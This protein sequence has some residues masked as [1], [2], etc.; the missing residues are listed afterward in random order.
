MQDEGPAPAGKEWPMVRAAF[1]IQETTNR[2]NQLLLVSLRWVAVAGQIAAIGA[3]RFGLGIPLP[4]PQMGAVIAC[5]IALNL[6][7]RYRHAS[8]R[9]VTDTELFLE[10]LLDVAALTV[11][12]YL[13]GGATNPFVSLFL[14]Q[15]ILG[16]V[17]LRPWATWLIVAVTSA[18]FVGLMAWY[19]D[20]GFIMPAHD[21][22]RPRLLELHIYG[23]FICFLLAAVLLVLFVTRINR[24]L[25]GQDLRLAG[26]RQQSAEEEHIVRMGLLASGAAHELGT[27][28]ATLS[29]ILNDWQRMPALTA[30]PDIATEIGEMQAQLARCKDIVSGILRSS[31]E[32][33]GEGAERAS[34]IAFLDDVVRDWSRSRG[35]TKLYYTNRLETDFVIASDALLKQILVNVL[36]NACEASPHW[37][38]VDA[39][40]EDDVMVIAVHDAGPGFSPEML[41]E[42][43]KPYRS[44]KG[45]PGRGLG[46]FLVVNVLRKLGGRA[47]AANLPL[48][49]AS[50]ELRLPI[51]ALAVEEDADGR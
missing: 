26:L 46:L 33:R 14:L 9:A 36:D 21:F 2:E 18:C 3:V 42:F 12:L 43:G 10:L 1:S 30:D 15:V 22:T 47:V 32:E 24:N 29:V 48:G 19:N 45:Q 39:A 41:A 40:E 5:L 27:P 17:L 34:I 50:V 44:T 25:R 38:S 13:S 23:M 28:L 49:G 6:V 31:G 11:Q 16:A 51:A 37:I 35:P 8:G 7:A 4:L 20:I